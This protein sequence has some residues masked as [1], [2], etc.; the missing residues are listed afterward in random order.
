MFKRFIIAGLT[1][2]VRSLLW[3]WFRCVVFVAC[4][5]SAAALDVKIR[6]N[7]GEMLM[8]GVTNLT[9]QV[10]VGPTELVL[11]DGYDVSITASN[12][13][14]TVSGINDLVGNFGS[15]IEI[16]AGTDGAS[17]TASGYLSGFQW[18][19]IGFGFGMVWFTT[20]LFWNI[21]RQIGRT[22]PEM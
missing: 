14:N 6:N 15:G 5:L 12:W 9:W 13:S 11:P 10:P 19:R 21:I 4:G 17:L 16:V 1:S 7:S 18:F 8:V 2:V 20:G 22:A 3:R